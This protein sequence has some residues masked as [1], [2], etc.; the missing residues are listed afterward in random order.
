LP[1]DAGRGG[2]IGTHQRGG[3]VREVGERGR[4]APDAKAGPQTGQP[5][6]RELHL[7]AALRRQQLVPLVDDQRLEV[8]EALAP[9]GARQEQREALRRG[10]EHR[11]QPP[12]LARA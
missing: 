8:R 3:C 9:V 7:H 4:Q 11:G 1:H 2:A 10:H 5:G 12:R 6:T